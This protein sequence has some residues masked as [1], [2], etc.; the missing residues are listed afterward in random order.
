[1]CP[2]SALSSGNDNGAVGHTTCLPQ[3]LQVVTDLVIQHLIQKDGT[4]ILGGGEL[5]NLLF[6]WNRSHLFLVVLDHATDS[7]FIDLLAKDLGEMV[8][9]CISTMKRPILPNLQLLF[10]GVVAVLTPLPLLA[11]VGTLHG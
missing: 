6:C 2:T 1:M 3:D 11:S 5:L 4:A 10:W 7:V 9:S 8:N